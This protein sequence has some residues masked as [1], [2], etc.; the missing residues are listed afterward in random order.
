MSAK[1]KFIIGRAGAGKTHKLYEGVRECERSSRRSFLIVPERATFET[2]RELSLFCG[3]G[4][5]HGAVVSWTSLARKTLA[6]S[7]QERAFLSS[8]GK[9]ML[10]R[11]AIDEVAPRLKAFSKVYMRAGFAGECDSIIARC[12]RCAI[13]PDALMGAGEQLSADD[14]LSDK[15]HDFA[16]I[17]EQLDRDMANR[18]IDGDDLLNFLIDALYD[19][20]CSDA[21]IFIDAPIGE[22]EFRIINSLMAVSAS[23]T[24]AIRGDFES[25]ARDDRLFYGDYGTYR[26]L[27]TMAGAQ[28][29]QVETSFL[30][31]RRRNAAAELI[32]LEQN[33]FAFPYNTYS[34][35][36]EAIELNASPD[37]HSEVTGAAEAISG[38]VRGGMRYRD[39]ALVVSDPEGYAPLIK[40]VFKAYGIPFFMDAPRPIIFHPASALILSALGCI[41]S[42]LRGREV[43]A[44]LKTGLTGVPREDCERLENH[45]LKYGLNGKRLTSEFPDDVPAALEQARRTLMKPLMKLRE[46]VSNA[47][48]R[49][50]T[51]ALFKYMDELRLNEQL[52]ALCERFSNAGELV[53]ARETAQVYETLMELLDQ[54]YVILGDERMGLRKYISIIEEG[55][56]AYSVGII[57][58]TCDQTIVGDAERTRTRNLKFLIVL[59]MNDGLLPRLRSDCDIINDLDLMRLK[60]AGLTVWDSS[61]TMNGKELAELYTLL[62]KPTERL[63]VSCAL[64]AGTDSAAPSTLFLKLGKLFPGAVRTGSASSSAIY[65]APEAALAALSQQL[66]S[67]IDGSSSPAGDCARLYAYFANAEGYAPIIKT[68]DN[69]YFEDNSPAP[70]G[71][72]LA[73][74]LYGRS[75][76]GSASRLE[77]FNQCPFRHFLQ[78]GLTL[79]ERDEHE[80][81][82]TDR[83]TFFHD[84]LD[85]FIKLFIENSVDPGALSREDVCALIDD[86]FLS[87][88]REHNGGILMESARMRS[89]AKRML[90][91]LYTTAW[92]ITCQLASGGFR[93]EA[94][95]V[96]FGG[97]GDVFPALTISAPGGA[98][99]LLRGIIDRLDSYADES[100]EYFRIIDYKSGNVKFDISELAAGIR[101]QLPLYSA[102]I[103]AALRVQRGCTAAGFYYMHVSDPAV[104]EPDESKL[105]Q[106]LLAE[107]KLRGLS[108]KAPNVIRA[109]GE[110]GAGN[111][112]NTLSGVRLLKS[113]E[114]SGMLADE[115]RMKG[116]LERAKQIAADTLNN[117]MKGAARISPCLYNG[118]SACKLCP[119]LS[120]C[121]FDTRIASNRYRRIKRID[122]SAF[123][124]E[125]AKHGAR[126]ETDQAEAPV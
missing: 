116:V 110:F 25:P 86:I 19:S 78:Y 82:Q 73:I 92:A 59:G 21:D 124:E 77:I 8:Q 29:A 69:M 22:Q 114:Y 72:E 30:K 41:Q 75:I 2:E 54:L 27:R 1:I 109:N 57:P 37:R 103:E 94:S 39:I 117:I 18:Y 61:E 7:A 74:E 113:G 42:G 63:R 43:I 87:L 97:P 47:D 46:A 60:A 119:Y 64:K 79:R 105:E 38:A 85:G 11:R 40:R 24:F 58:T 93:P 111:Y 56:R 126:S 4:L 71:H 23:I 6:R 13:A 48:S 26:R 32:H 70:F 33:L 16:L 88:I 125:A 62:S 83:G 3:G 35:P 96:S 17:Y 34:G 9:R 52:G 101:L 100:G 44:L 49:A 68:L 90:R 121:R 81:L 120:V 102:A 50:R 80:E 28:G 53:R 67:M 14:M 123:M 65:S 55:L 98:N 91:T 45:I 20:P 115:A 76:K 112:S 5:I 108:L 95:E 107:F 12:K 99:F 106:K 118:V 31:D 84:A 15:L 36:A 89:E 122:A 104:D 10:V 51:E 66:R